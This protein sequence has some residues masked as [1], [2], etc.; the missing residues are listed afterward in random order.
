[1]R[2]LILQRISYFHKE[3]H[4]GTTGV[5]LD[6]V[7]LVPF[8][9]TLELPW[10][11]NQVNVSCIPSGIYHCKRTDSPRFG[12]T[13]EVTDVFKRTHILFHKGNL[14]DHTKGCILLGE[15]F[16]LLRGEPAILSSRNAFT[17]FMYKLKNENEFILDLRSP[18]VYQNPYS[19]F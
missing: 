6:Q 1:M 15:Q 5:L 16:G 3:E 12:E 14:D 4:K 8:C 2:T 19:S 10:K 7:G 11:Q 17:E 9:L 18:A 13:F